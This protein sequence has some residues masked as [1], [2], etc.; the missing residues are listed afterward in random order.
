[1]RLRRRP[2]RQGGIIGAGIGAVKPQIDSQA[3]GSRSR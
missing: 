3:A 1:V 2:A